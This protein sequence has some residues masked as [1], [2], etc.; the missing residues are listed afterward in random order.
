[1]VAENI[2]CQVCRW[3]NPQ[4]F[5]D[6]GH[7]SLDDCETVESVLRKLR[8]R[9]QPSDNAEDEEVRTIEGFMDQLIFLA[10]SYEPD[11]HQPGQNWLDFESLK[12]NA[13]AYRKRFEDSAA[14]H[15]VGELVWSWF[16]PDNLKHHTMKGWSPQSKVRFILLDFGIFYN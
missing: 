9:I 8:H 5:A 3:I 11:F 1:M 10:E 2:A 16:G 6:G 12:L 14:W 7:G 4:C 15:R 13:S